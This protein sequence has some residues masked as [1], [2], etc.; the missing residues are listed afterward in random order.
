MAE[1]P[2]SQV[3]TPV[4]VGG[5]WYDVRHRHLE[6]VAYLVNRLTGIGLVVYLYVHLA[7]L[8]QLTRGSAD[9]NSFLSTA[10]GPFF[11]ALDA[12]VLVGVLFH[13]LNGIRLAVTGAG[14]AVRWQRLMLKVVVLLALALFLAAGLVWSLRG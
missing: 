9:W 2:T 14:V 6:A 11:T 5:A 13:G 7:V 1:T 10:T 3:P 4:R 8:G 12:L